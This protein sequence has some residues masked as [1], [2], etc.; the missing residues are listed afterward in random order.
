MIERVDISLIEKYLAGEVEQLVDEKGSVLTPTEVAQVIEEYHEVII[1]LEGAAFKSELEARYGREKGK[2]YP[3][4]RLYTLAAAV[5]LLVIAFVFLWQSNAGPQFDD[6]FKHFAQL[7]TNRGEV[8]T[9]YTDALVAYSRQRYE[10]AFVL[11]SSLE[12][13]SNE[14][15]FF[16]G[17]SALATNQA[18]AAIEA[19]QKSGLEKPSRYYQQARW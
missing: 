16:M 10:E 9:T 19:L 4:K 12:S 6:Y 11:F 14:A 15:L 7:E 3:L 13:P 2:T 5:I 1:Q 18:E 8:G 17:V